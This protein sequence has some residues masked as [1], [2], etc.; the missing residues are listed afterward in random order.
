MFRF[1]VCAV[2]L[3]WSFGSEF[4]NDLQSVFGDKHCVDASLISIP[5]NIDTYVMFSSESQNNVTKTPEKN[6]VATI[7]EL[8]QFNEIECSY[9]LI[10][11]EGPPHAK[12]FKVSL[13]LGDELYEGSGSSLKKAQQAAATLALQD[14]FYSHPPEKINTPQEKSL[15][16]T[17]ALNNVAAKLG[18]AVSYFLLNGKEEQTIDSYG[19]V[20][21]SYGKS[22]SSFPK[23]NATFDPLKV[24]LE[25]A[26][27]SGPFAVR[28]KAGDSVFEGFGQTIQAARHDAASKALKDMEKRA[29]LKD[30]VC[31]R[32]DS[33][34]DCKKLKDDLKSPI[35]RVHEAAQLNNLALEFNVISESGKPHQRNFVTECK[36]GDYVTEGEGRSK[37]ESKRVAAEKMLQFLPQLHDTYNEKAII[38]GLQNK[39][40]KKKN[41]KNKVKRENVDTMMNSINTM[42]HSVLGTVS[43][44]SSD[45][46]SDSST[47]PKRGAS[48]S[49]SPYASPK[50]K[51]L[52]IGNKLNINVEFTDLIKQDN[53]YYTLVSLGLKPP[54]VCLGKA[55]VQAKSHEDAAL[56]G[57]Q[58][59]RKSGILDKTGFAEE[60]KQVEDVF[61]VGNEE[62]YRILDDFEE[63]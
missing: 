55:A 41:K 13:H 9:T 57:L 23:W 28:V 16:P 42:V 4:V 18:I 51:L 27:I 54:H 14:T 45:E 47:Q 11:E 63:K 17:V 26:Q 22:K 30:H 20:D 1:L 39:Q 32:E 44:A 36:L 2:I 3:K 62:Q 5:S 46:S 8:A 48:S 10:S 53:Q 50:T 19:A 35:T 56:R 43:V 29:L 38:S 49:N 31:S 12:I 6:I 60:S 37:K 34:E 58:L 7:Y 25:D 21:E 24:P 15:T 40:K 33:V 61:E 52:E 59:L